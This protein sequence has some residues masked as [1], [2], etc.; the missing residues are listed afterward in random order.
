MKFI[1]RIKEDYIVF[2]ERLRRK[3][4]QGG[5]DNPDLR[6]KIRIRRICIV[7]IAALIAI[8]MIYGIIYGI[9]RLVEKCTS[10]KNA[11]NAVVMEEGQILDG[12]FFYNPE[13]PKG[14]NVYILDTF[15]DEG[16]VKY[17]IKYQDRVGTISSQKIKYFSI[18]TNSEHILMSD[19]SHFDTNTNFKT[20]N[21][22]EVFLL[23]NNIK[24]VYIRAGGRG[25]GEEGNFYY[26]KQYQ[27]FINACE[28]LKIPYGF[29]FLDEALNEEEADEE[30]DWIK[31]FVNEHSTTCNVLPIAIDIEYFDGKG[32]GDEK[33]DER[34]AIIEYL[35]NKLD[36]SKLDN[37]IYANA[38]R[39][40]QYL[41]TINNYF[42]LAY[43]PTLDTIPNNWLS[44]MSDQEAANNEELMAKTIAWQFTES[45]AS[46]SGINIKVDMN[47][48]KNNYFGK[49]ID[50]WNNK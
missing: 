34:V 12:S 10:T 4:N 41:S 31:E 49:F 48:I 25:Y 28:Y 18:D 5:I 33:W 46:G 44:D 17:K 30:V 32:R 9:S 21:D 29:Y 24:Y 16:E 23:K 47:L 11:I 39:A 43:Y 14:A 35:G 7:T 45:G 6:N 8:F 50:K 42:W 22:Y 13:L 37:I 20:E 36:E 19:V 15:I 2:R 38:K 40:S 1:T 27:L 3:L 26:D